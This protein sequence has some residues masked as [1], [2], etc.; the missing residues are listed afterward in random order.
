M[1]FARLPGFKAF[2]SAVLLAVFFA[3]VYVGPSG[4]RLSAADQG[5][6]GAVTV[7]YA[8]SSVLLVILKEKGLLEAALASEGLKVEWKSLQAGL[9]MIEAVA[10]GE[11]DLAGDVPAAVPIFA[12]SM[13]VDFAYYLQE[14]PSPGSQAIV[15]MEGSDIFGPQDLKGRKIALAKASGAHY[16]AVTVVRAA[17]LSIGRN[18]E[19][20]FL[21]PGEAAL[22][23]ETGEVDAWA[24]EGESL[25]ALEAKGEARRIGEQAG[26][27]P[28]FYL[29]NTAFLN[30]RPN[31][32]LIIQK[33]I[34]KIGAWAK[35]NPEEAAAAVA[36]AEAEADSKDAGDAEA[37]LEAEALKLKCSPRSFSIAAVGLEAL[38]E[39]QKMADAFSEEKLLYRPVRIAETPAWLKGP[40]ASP[41]APDPETR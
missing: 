12:Q 18:V 24:A 16:L 11:A 35:D 21:K 17:E 8:P 5:G 37:G 40:P 1:P 4:G 25:C 3:L 32:A 39:Q 20:A 15:V 19:F 9:P 33:E 30:E 36:K 13:G 26:G 29:A 38:R 31:A 28:R 22:A 41:A 34:E 10:L 2:F 6:L 7:G 23:L 14:R 27:E